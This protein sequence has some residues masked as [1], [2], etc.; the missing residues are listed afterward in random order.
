MTQEKSPTFSFYILIFD[1]RLHNIITEGTDAS[2]TWSSRKGISFS[3]KEYK[4]KKIMVLKIIYKN[5][6]FTSPVEGDNS[7][8][9]NDILNP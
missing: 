4:I 7:E 6:F 1:Q 2:S 9:I 8:D 5:F 3:K